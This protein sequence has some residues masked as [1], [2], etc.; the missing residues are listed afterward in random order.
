MLCLT[1]GCVV[2]LRDE[3]NRKEQELE[4]SKEKDAIIQKLR[5]RVSS[6]HMSRLILAEL[7]KWETAACPLC[8]PRIMLGVFFFVEKVA[9]FF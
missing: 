4:S 6:E 9:L 8:F 5:S 1:G 2:R 3:C 7:V